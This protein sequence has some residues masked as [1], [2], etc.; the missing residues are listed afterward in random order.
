MKDTAQLK[1]LAKINLGLDVT[2]RRENG[3]HDVRMVMQ[4]IYLY[5]D[6][7]IK[8]TEEP[9]IVVKTNLSFL[10]INE[11]N[12]AYKAAKML[13]DEF[14]IEQG[15]EITLD[16]HIPVAAG[17]AGGSSNAAAVLVGMNQMFDLKLSQQ[18]LMDRGVKL[19]ADVPYCV[20][21]GTVLAEVI[22]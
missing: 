12:I 11:D 14:G 21:R 22:G 6:V 4:T 13:I 1:A 7:L 19:G 9:G 10:P 20:M 15:V 18:D 3:Y 2:G 16:K 17:L 5:D 8:K